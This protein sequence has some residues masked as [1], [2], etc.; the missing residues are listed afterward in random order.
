MFLHLSIT[1]I[2][3]LI[4]QDH[5]EQKLPFKKKKKR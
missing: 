5:L 1:F 3:Q 2:I 4:G